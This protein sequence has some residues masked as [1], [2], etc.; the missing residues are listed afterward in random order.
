MRSRMTSHPAR[1]WRCWAT[2]SRLWQM[3]QRPDTS[4]R[5]FPGGSGL[6]WA[7]DRSAAQP[8]RTP[9]AS[10]PPSSAAVLRHIDPYG[11]DHVPAIAL[12]IRRAARRLHAAQRVRRAGHQGLRAALGVPGELPAPP[13]V[14]VLVAA[15]PRGDPAL[16][17]V[18]GDVHG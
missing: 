2:I 13:G 4:S 3:M 7:A 12:R 5:F 16:A 11:V 10:A 17:A 14:A 9:T 18:G 1:S 8:S 6:F 15:E